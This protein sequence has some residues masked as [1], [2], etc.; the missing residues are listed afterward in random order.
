MTS[1]FKDSVRL[2]QAEEDMFMVTPAQKE[3][4]D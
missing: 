3:T 2:S 1:K 4:M